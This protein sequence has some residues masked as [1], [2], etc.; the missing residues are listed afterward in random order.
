MI[1]ALRKLIQF[2]EL[3]LSIISYGPTGFITYAV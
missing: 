2:L 3:K 1:I